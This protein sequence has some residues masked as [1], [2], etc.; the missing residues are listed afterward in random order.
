MALNGQLAGKLR[1][2]GGFLADGAQS[3]AIARFLRL[4]DWGSWRE[5]DGSPL[6]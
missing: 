4:G 3:C 2:V 5:A 1:R 6:S